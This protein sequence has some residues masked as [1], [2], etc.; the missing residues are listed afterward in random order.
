M[1]ALLFGLGFGAAVGA[2]RGAALPNPQRSL[3]VFLFLF[4]LVVSYL[5]GR[6]RAPVAVA[7]ASAE[8]N[9]TAAAA[10]EGGNAVAV[11]NLHLNG[12]KYEPTALDRFAERGRPA[13]TAEEILSIAPED[14]YAALEVWD[15]SPGEAVEVFENDVE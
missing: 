7:M 10:A 8:A 1:K 15:K 6:R 9:A 13:L 3:V 12:E 4:G 2:V 11:F 14:P 5:S